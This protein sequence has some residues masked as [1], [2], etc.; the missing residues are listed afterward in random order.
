MDLGQF[1]KEKIKNALYNKA[2]NVEIEALTLLKGKAAVISSR[3]LH[4][5][6]IQLL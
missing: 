5:E 4:P 1:H 3:V 6:T 2:F